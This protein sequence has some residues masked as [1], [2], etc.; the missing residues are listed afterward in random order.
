MCTTAI[1]SGST[2]SRPTRPWSPRTRRCTGRSGR[3]EGP[4]GLDPPPKPR[5]ARP[6][7]HGPHLAVDVVDEHHDRS[8]GGQAREE[9][10]AVLGV[11]HDI[12]AAQSVERELGPASRQ[13]AELASASTETHAGAD[14][15]PGRRPVVGREDG[16][17]VTGVRQGLGDDLPVALG[18]APLGVG[19]VPPVEHHHRQGSCCGVCHGVTSS[20]VAR[21]RRHST[22]TVVAGARPYESVRYRP[23]DVCRTGA[24]GTA[25]PLWRARSRCFGRF[26]PSSPTRLASTGRLARDSVAQLLS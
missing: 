18:A 9:G 24:V 8:P 10:H 15:V 5:G 26:G 7:D 1:R 12:D 25:T 16:D 11:H 2:P 13:D 6:V 23:V 22:L 20:S 3:G 14:L 21:R 4:L 19:G 17:I